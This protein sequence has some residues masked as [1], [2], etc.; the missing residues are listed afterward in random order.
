MVV[1]SEVKHK[2]KTMIEV[3]TGQAFDFAFQYVTVCESTLGIVDFSPFIKLIWEQHRQ[4]AFAS[5]VR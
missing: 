5:V 1:N 2:S 3:I 4:L